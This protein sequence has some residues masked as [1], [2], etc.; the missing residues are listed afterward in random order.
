MIDS[1]FLLALDSLAEEGVDSPDNN[2]PVLELDDSPQ[3]VEE[4]VVEETMSA[5][6]HQDNVDVVIP[7]STMLYSRSPKLV[8]VVQKEVKRSSFREAPI[9]Q[10]LIVN[11]QE[12]T[13]L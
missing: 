11:L 8:S 3:Y 7:S 1:H 12:E 2:F 6:R 4:N 10:P 13:I 5:S 9:C